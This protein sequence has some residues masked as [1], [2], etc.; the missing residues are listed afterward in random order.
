V[1]PDLHSASLLLAILLLSACVAADERERDAANLRDPWSVATVPSD[2]T[3][4]AGQQVFDSCAS[5]HLADAG[6]R[7][8]GTIPRLAGQQAAI[9]ERRLRGLGDG[10]IDL[11]VMTPFAR[12][13]T[14]TEIRQVSAYLSSLPRPEQIGVG[15]GGASEHG[16]ALYAGLCL[17][18][19]AADAV[20][21]PALN[22]PRLC[23]QHEAYLLRRL[24]EMANA[25]APKARLVDPAM[26]VIAAALPVDDRR[27]VSHYL[28]ELECDG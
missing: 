26:G 3:R 10:S 13:L 28:A 11:P 4:A 20:G 15:R 18:C 24:D 9:L 27:A 6:G 25:N 2:P 23:G 12:A 8:D 16:A 19:H 1:H 17:S 7:A 5:C 14:N 21:Q 22:A